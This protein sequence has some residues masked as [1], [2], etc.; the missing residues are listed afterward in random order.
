MQPPPPPSP[1]P[2][3]IEEARFLYT[4]MRLSS[5]SPSL[6][7]SGSSSA[8]SS[9]GESSEAFV[10]LAVIRAKPDRGEEM[11]EFLKGTS[12]RVLA[13]ENGIISHR[14][15]RCVDEEDEVLGC[16]FVAYVEFADDE[17]FD[18]H[19]QSEEFQKLVDNSDL[20]KEA[21]A[22]FFLRDT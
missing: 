9:S 1:T 16:K 5:R 15:L 19:L 11:A 20:V 21:P 14:I 18:Q 17:S 8:S 10:W 3:E 2:S 12:E 6:N 22:I 4:S 7:G 13:N